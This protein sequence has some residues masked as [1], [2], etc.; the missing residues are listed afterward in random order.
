MKIQPCRVGFSRDGKM[1]H[2]TAKK[3]QIFKCLKYQK[4]C[5]SQLWMRFVLGNSSEFLWPKVH[6]VFLGKESI[7]YL[8]K[9]PST[10]VL[11]KI[12]SENM[13]QVYRRTLISKGVSI[14]LLCNFIEIT[15]RHGCFF[16][17][18]AAYFQNTFSW[19]YLWR[20]TSDLRLNF[21][22]RK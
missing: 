1:L 16:C 20:A 11:R 10:G 14:K 22:W 18:C 19:E 9:Q 17:K 4:A 21:F 12:C 2:N 15:L 5:L 6:S 3:N 8:Q 7:S 13:Q